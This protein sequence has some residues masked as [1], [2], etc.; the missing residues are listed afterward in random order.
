MTTALI[1]AAVGLLFA[2]VIWFLVQQ[3]RNQGRAE[4]EEKAMEKIIDAAT[5]RAKV[6]SQNS[7]RSTD[8]LRDRLLRDS[9]DR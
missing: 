9:S 5:E 6:D 1:I 7:Q 2:G 8:E 3:A 4:A